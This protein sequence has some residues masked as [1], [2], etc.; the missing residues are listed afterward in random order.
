MSEARLANLTGALAGHGLELRGGFPPDDHDLSELGEGAGAATQVVI[1]GN[2]GRAMHTVFAA[3]AEA[4]DGRPNPLDR[5]TRRA[6]DAIAAVSGARAVYPFDGPPWLP[7]QRWA[8]RADP[9][10]HVSPTGI[11]I[12]PDYGL[13]HALRA[14]LLLEEPLPLPAPVPRPAPCAACAAKPCLTACPVDAIRPDEFR[15]GDCRAYLGTLSGQG[16]MM[17]GCAARRAC[18]V[19]GAYAY[20]QAQATFHMRAFRTG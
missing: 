10:L 13:W 9:A 3:S 20:G 15:V 17:L 5:W 12:H 7:F 11:L 14:A 18:P 8:M 2:A 19:G 6:V 16:C 1:V 4:R